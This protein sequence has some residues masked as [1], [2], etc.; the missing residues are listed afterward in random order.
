MTRILHIIINVVIVYSSLFSIN[1]FVT[2]QGIRSIHINNHR[3]Y[4]YSCL[5]KTTDIE[6]DRN[7]DIDVGVGFPNLIDKRPQSALFFAFHNFQRELKQLTSSNPINEH[8]IATKNN[9]NN[10]LLNKLILTN[11]F[12]VKIEKEREERDGHTDFNPVA[13]QSFNFACFLIDKFFNERPIARF[14]FLE[15]FARI[16]YFSYISIL[17]LYETLGWWRQPLLRRVHH[18]E[19]WNELHHLL[20]M[21]SL[22]GN[23]VSFKYRCYIES[24]IFIFLG[25]V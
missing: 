6:S 23:E 5:K 11:D 15:I 18:E 13:R 14:W 8:T 10:Q 16:P 19:E 7:N 2:F 22:G 3:K 20:I 21:E 24:S 25:L 9:N 4:Q 1:S 17:H 12:V